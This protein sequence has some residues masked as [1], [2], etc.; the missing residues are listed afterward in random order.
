MAQYQVTHSC[1]HTVTHQIY[2][3][4][5]HGERDRKVQWLRGRTCKACYAKANPQP[6]RA[7]IYPASTLSPSQDQIR[8]AVINAYDQRA[9]LKDRGYRFDQAAHWRDALGATV[10]AGWVYETGDLDAAMAEVDALDALGAELV[11]RDDVQAV[12]DSVSI[13]AALGVY[14]T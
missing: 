9:T 2:G 5:S 8:I 4:N 13:A 7:I 1:G 10:D 11:L 6:L 14:N 12:K 3:T